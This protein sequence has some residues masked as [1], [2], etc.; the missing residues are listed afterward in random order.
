MGLGLPRGWGCHGAG[1]VPGS[2]LGGLDR[3]PLGL[4]GAGLWGDMQAA[5]LSPPGCP[6]YGAGTNPAPV[7]SLPHRCRRPACPHPLPA[8]R[9]VPPACWGA[10]AGTSSLLTRAPSPSAS[11]PGHHG[12]APACPS[13]PSMAATSLLS[14]VQGTGDIEGSGGDT[15]P[16]PPTSAAP[17]H[18]PAP[19]T[20]TPINLGLTAPACPTLCEG[21]RAHYGGV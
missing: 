14:V 15:L 6:G 10:A 20:P 18:L 3:A 12:A 13:H 8:P 7:L 21:A 11:S 1:A 16:V 17:Q 2:P 4:C 5:P 19:S 9:C